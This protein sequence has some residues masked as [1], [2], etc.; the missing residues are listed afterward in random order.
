MK[1]FKSQQM[2]KLHCGESF[3]ILSM[4]MEHDFIARQWKGQI[5]TIK[6]SDIVPGSF[7]MVKE[8]HYS[9][10]ERLNTEFPFVCF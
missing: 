2:M 7:V 5:A 4:P 6:P 9:S 3:V 8:K 10:F 1:T